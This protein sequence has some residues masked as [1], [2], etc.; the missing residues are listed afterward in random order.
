MSLVTIAGT[1]RKMGLD[2]YQRKRDFNRTPEPEGDAGRSVSGQKFVVQKHA[3]SRLHYDF[4]LEMQGVLKSWAVPK[5]PSL[6]PS[7][8][9]LAVH[10]EDHPLEYGGFEGVIPEGEYGGGTVML[11]DQGIWE[12]KGDPVKGYEKGDLKFILHGAKL[13]GEWAL[14]RMHAKEEDAKNWLLLKKK[15]GESSRQ[16]DILEEAPLSVSSGRSLEEI[17]SREDRVWTSAGEKDGSEWTVAEH[18]PETVAIDPAVLQNARKAKQPETVRPQLATLTAQVPEGENWLH[19][20]KYDGYRILL[21]LKDG[22]VRLLTRRGNDWTDKFREIARVGETLPVDRAVLDGEVVVQRPDGTTDFQSLQNVLK[23]V[24]KEHLLYYVFDIVHCQGFDLTGAPLLERKDLLRKLITGMANQQTIK[25]SDHILGQGRM[26]Y[27][28]A[29]RLAL[30]GIVSK[31]AQSRYEH[32]RTRTWLKVKCQFRQEFVIGGFTDPS[33]SRVGFGALLLGVHDREGSLV[34]AGKVGTG[35]T[36]ELLQSLRKEMEQLQR[37]D[38][39]FAN[40]PQG[41]EAKGVHWIEPRLVGEVEFTEWTKEGILRHP[42]FKG[43]RKDKS[44]RDVVREVPGS[45]GDQAGPVSSKADPAKRTRIREDMMIAGVKLTSPDKILYP[46]QGVT[47]KELAGFYEDIGEQMLPHL[48]GRPLTLVRCPQGR[49]KE[50]FYQKHATDELK[51]YVDSVQVKEKEGSR[52]YVMVKNLRGLIGLVQMGT[53]EFHPWGSRA[54]ML[55]RPDTMVFDLDPDEGLDW[56]RVTG[57][58]RELKERLE[59]LGLAGFVKTTG[60]KGLHVFVPLSRRAGWD[61]IKEFSA[62]VA[63]GM[64]RDSPNAYVATMTKS[65]RR[66]KVFID[67][68]RNSR[69]STS[70]CAYSTRAR[71]NAPVSV[72]LRWDE[73]SPKIRS[74]HYT[75]ANL[76]RRLIALKEDPWEGYFQ[77]RQSIT[78]EMRKAVGMKG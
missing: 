6:D 33:G 42:S 48:E 74:D 3:A 61:E 35:F 5:G 41:R 31:D 36:D 52:P 44:P 49:E 69:G 51:E 10:V 45:S 57:A 16:R 22:R 76:R 60:G 65:K 27:H 8:R 4:R 15:D 28:N 53:L 68:F 70:V 11:W 7:D 14:V 43:I 78:R 71:P 58:A 26:V 23:G 63:E 18:R 12:P 25:Y 34:Y 24:E 29:C 64:V 77:V 75:V 39:P 56:S 17:R 73:L 30:E 40:P 59:S 37:S 13:K 20:I 1:E 50:C 67:Y 66:G 9:R 2:E 72:P 54:D 32:K 46:E 21:V 62:A 19:E 47:K 55:D 38:P